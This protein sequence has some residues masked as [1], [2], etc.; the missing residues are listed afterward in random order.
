MLIINTHKRRKQKKRF[1]KS[2]FYSNLSRQKNQFIYYI[3][4]EFKNSN[5][6][7]FQNSKFNSNLYFVKKKR[8][9]NP[10]H[11]AL[12][13][14]QKKNLIKIQRW[15]LKFHRCKHNRKIVWRSKHIN[16]ILTNLVYS[17]QSVI[18][19]RSRAVGTHSLKF[20]P[21]PLVPSYYALAR[22]QFDLSGIHEP[23]RNEICSI[24]TNR[25]RNNV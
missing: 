5:W 19:C 11:Y 6:H 15:I 20:F 16:A 17:I 4:Y 10:H 3:S 9:S 1:Y 12:I 2:K 23:I 22:S 18:A 8:T 13:S 25:S 14:F 24:L 21:F 7:Q